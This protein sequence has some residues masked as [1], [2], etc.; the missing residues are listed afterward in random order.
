MNYVETLCRGGKL[1]RSFHQKQR[2]WNLKLSGCFFFGETCDEF[3]NT[4]ILTGI[5]P[6]VQEMAMLEE[7]EGYDKK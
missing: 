4:R 5:W 6:N 7:R 3:Q 2:S 1:G